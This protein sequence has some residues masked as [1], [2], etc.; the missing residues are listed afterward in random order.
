MRQ[1]WIKWGII[2]AAIP[3]LLFIGVVVAERYY[4]QPL[5][6]KT[7]KKSVSETSDGMY[8]I[9]FEKLMY[10]PFAGNAQLTHIKLIPDTLLY[11]QRMDN[12]STSNFIYGTYIEE[13]RLTDI[14]LFKLV[15]QR[16][17]DIGLIRINKPTVEITQRKQDEKPKKSS[18]SPYTMI[19][20]FVKSFRVRKIEFDQMKFAFADETKKRPE[21][22]VLN[23][24]NINITDFLIDSLSARDTTRFYYSKNTAFELLNLDFPSVSPLHDFRLD[25]IS[26]SS[27]QRQI[28]VKGIHYM[29]KFKGLQFTTRA[30]GDDR[31]AFTFGDITVNEVDL[32]ALVFDKKLV[33]HRAHIQRGGID[34]FGDGTYPAVA[35]KVG[36]YP[37]QLFRN[38]NF[39]MKLDTVRVENFLI[40]YSEYNPDT[41]GRGGVNFKLVKGD[42]FNVT[43]DTLPLAKN[44]I[45]EARI[46]SLF[47]GVAPLSTHFT[48]N[49]ASKK[50][51]FTC[52]GSLGAI[53]LKR[54]NEVTE[55]LALT[56][57]ESGKVKSF[58]FIMK[59]DEY[60]VRGRGTLI[61]H[62]LKTV[63]LKQDDDG[64]VKKRKL[65]TGLADAIFIQDHNP[66]PNEPTRIG[67]IEYTR[68]PK[69]SYFA[70]LWRSLRQAIAKCVLKRKGLKKLKKIGRH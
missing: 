44:P 69:K 34:I 61:Y 23:K 14:Q 32:N 68:D 24:L 12:I 11:R 22:I 30:D 35:S 13:I 70:T 48:F 63:F 16:K 3:A 19:S 45:C 36:K 58:K 42:L 56:K 41:E 37:Q 15:V 25:T 20:K 6:A 8:R 29:P 67:E 52:E 21:R 53:D 40:S 65:I 51:D 66:W 55:P 1:K 2:F 33:A 17:L 38:L 27:E 18:A 28:Q 59:G 54:I 49:I 47:M 7:L 9:E 50:G 64:N 43:N 5:L 46:E 10:E 60:G 31:I 39:K 62:D 26:F 4:L 57:I